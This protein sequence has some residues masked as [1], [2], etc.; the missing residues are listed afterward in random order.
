[1][2]RS[3]GNRIPPLSKSYRA[4]CNQNILI[5]SYLENA[6]D[7]ALAAHGNAL[8]RTLVRELCVELTE[9]GLHPE[10]VR[11]VKHA[12]L[13]RI[14]WLQDHGFVVRGANKGTIVKTQCKSLS[15]LGRLGS[16]SGGCIDLSHDETDAGQRAGAPFKRLAGS[17]KGSRYRKE[18]I[19]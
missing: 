3:K 17:C 8:Q 11:F 9:E 14:L 13:P 6:V 1:M 16:G 4:K 15:G 19:K 18:V 7:A 10:K 12:S 2:P 5:D